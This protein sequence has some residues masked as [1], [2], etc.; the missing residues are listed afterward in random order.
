MS[1]PTTT[2]KY[3]S[4]LTTSTTGLRVKGVVFDMDGTLTLPLKN[5][6]GEMRRRLQVPDKV[7]VLAY[8]AS[9]PPEE[10][11]RAEKIIEDVEVEALERVEIQ[12]GLEE[13]IQFLEEHHIPKAILTRNNERAVTHLLDMTGHHFDP[14]VTRAFLPTKPH[15]DPLFHIAR[16]WGFA[17]EEL[18]MVGD[19]GDDLSCAK[20]AGSVGVLLRHRANEPF[21]SQAD[22]VLDRLEDL[23]VPLRDGF[24]VKRP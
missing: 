12:P 16:T 17:P 9:L 18:M 4:S 21:I 15:P 6:I 11:I 1:S 22:I 3:L 19:F 5:F 2:S 13:L 14:L 23:I 10:K 24:E 8:A 20:G 7:D